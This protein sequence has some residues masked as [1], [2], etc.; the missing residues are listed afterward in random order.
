ML[1]AE[2]PRAAPKEGVLLRHQPFALVKSEGTT[3]R[4]LIPSTLPL[5][6][7]NRS[8]ALHQ[9]E[10]AISSEEVRMVGGL[11]PCLAGQ[12]SEDRNHGG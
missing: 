2:R 1:V 4:A 8:P 5:G 3:G 10:R 7:K 6:F 12:P 11:C 9:E